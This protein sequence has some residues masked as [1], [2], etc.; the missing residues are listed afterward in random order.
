VSINDI[1]LVV[2]ENADRD[3][4]SAFLD[5]APSNV[6]QFSSLTSRIAAGQADIND[7]RRRQANCAFPSKVR[8]TLWGIRGIAALVTPYRGCA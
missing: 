8:P 1:S 7:M 5:E 3:V 2:P 6:E 4:Y